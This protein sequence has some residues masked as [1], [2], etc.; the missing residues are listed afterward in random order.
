MSDTLAWVC[1]LLS[2]SKGCM[3]ILARFTHSEPRLWYHWSSRYIFRRSPEEYTGESAY[4]NQ[5]W[6][7]AKKR[8]SLFSYLLDR[9]TQSIEGLPTHDA[10]VADYKRAAEIHVFKRKTDTIDEDFW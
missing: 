4:V 7:S 3:A 1:G 6:R 9:S 10:D 2:R 5:H 8:E